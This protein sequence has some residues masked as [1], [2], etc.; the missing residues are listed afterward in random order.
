MRIKKHIKV[1]LQQT[2]LG[3]CG[4]TKSKR[5]SL[6]PQFKDIAKR[7]EKEKKLEK[8]KREL[9]MKIR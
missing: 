3:I 2:D 8:K 4:N 7:E 5:T 9:R 1:F 6:H